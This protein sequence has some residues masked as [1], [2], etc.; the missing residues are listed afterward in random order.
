MSDDALAVAIGL[1]VEPGEDL[2]APVADAA[3]DAEAAWAAADVAPIAQG[4]DRD[5]DNVGNFLHGQQFVVGARGVGLSGPLGATHR[6]PPGGLPV[7]V[8]G[9]RRVAV[10]L[11]KDRG[12]V[13][14]V[15]GEEEASPPSYPRVYPLWGTSCLR[16][17]DIG[18]ELIGEAFAYSPAGDDGAWPAEPLCDLLEVIGSRELENRIVLGKLNSRGFTTRVVYEGGHQERQLAQQYR[19]WNKMTRAR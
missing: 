2:P 8:R 10:L 6:V 15:N 17:S 11:H 14:V 19:E 5:A 4:C 18:D 13:P 3:A 12:Q 1:V 9:C 7:V 16:R